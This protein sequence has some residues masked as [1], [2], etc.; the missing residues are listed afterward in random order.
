MLKNVVSYLNRLVS[1]SKVKCP[2][3]LAP[4]TSSIADSIPTTKNDSNNQQSNNFTRRP[5]K[6]IL[7]KASR[8]PA[9][10]TVDKMP[11]VSSNHDTPI[12]WMDLE[13][14]GLDISKDVIMEVGCIVTNPNLDEIARLPE[15]IINVPGSLLD[16]MDSWCV[17]THGASG[18]TDACRNSS[19][20]NSEAEDKLLEF[21]K[22]HTDPGIC[23]LGGN[24]IT[25]DRIF[26]KKYM[27]K[28][29]DHLHYRSIDVSTLKELVRRWYPKEFSE[30]PQKRFIH[31]TM[32]DI[33][34]SISELK[35]YR[36]KFFVPVPPTLEQSTGQGSSL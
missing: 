35:Y 21:L 29:L 8:A 23:P 9:S 15:M 2:G 33:E 5:T 31:K 12:V 27:P 22:Q 25:Y 7:V 34:D 16:S 3:I 13:M 20:S 1:I 6:A 26:L 18:L 17:S 32:A 10:K 19:L 28:V 11:S 14:T 30:C 4:V 24:S 36:S